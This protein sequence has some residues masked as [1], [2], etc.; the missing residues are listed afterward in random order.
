VGSR[1]GIYNFR[2]WCCHLYSRS[3]SVMQQ[4]MTALTYFGSQ[5]TK[6][7]ASVW[8][9][10]FF[11]SFYLEHRRLCI[12]FCAKLRKCAA[13]TLAMIILAYSIQGRLKKSRQVKNKTKSVHISFCDIEVIVYK[14]F[15]LS[16]QAISS[17]YYCDV[18]RW[19]LKNVWRLRPELW[20]QK[21]WL[22]HHD[23][24]PSHTA[25]F[26]RV[27]FTKNNMT[28]LPLSPWIFLFSDWR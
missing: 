6:F 10:W 12:K 11:T 16:G 18:L 9:Y 26:T 19:L 4:Y 15:I 17:T 8:K 22:L 13:E 3:S 1:R 27:F 21:S 25:S 28:A 20:R 24:S 23:S 7:H 5:R 2:D 14:G